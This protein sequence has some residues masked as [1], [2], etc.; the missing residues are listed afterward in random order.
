MSQP[1]RGAPASAGPRIVGGEVAP[2][3]EGEE[4]RQSRTSLSRD[5]NREN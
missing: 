2:A 5:Q 3:L 4:G 1:D